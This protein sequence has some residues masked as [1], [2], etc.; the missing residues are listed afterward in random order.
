MNKSQ[1]KV[2]DTV[3]IKSGLHRGDWGVVKM[4][5]ED[6]NYHVAMMGDSN[7]CPIFQRNEI[8]R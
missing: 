3:T 5:D 8:K 4:I 1:I 6:K 7:F 2:G